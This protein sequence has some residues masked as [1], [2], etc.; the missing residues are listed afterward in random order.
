MGARLTGVR[1]PGTLLE[2]TFLAR[3]KRFFADV[4]LP[5][6]REVVAHCANTGSMGGLLAP[7][8]RCR[9]SWHDNPKRKLAWSLEQ[10]EIHGTWVMVN[11]ARPNHIVA[12]ALLADGI[13]ELRGFE[14]LY[15][16]QPYGERNS[17]VDLLLTG[18]G[19]PPERARGRAPVD[20]EPRC[21]VEVKNATL[22][23]GSEARFPDAVTARGTRH[24]EELALMVRRG[25]GAAL[26]WHIARSDASSF[27]PADDID[28]AYGA[29]VRAAARAGVKLFAWTTR[30]EA[31][32]VSLAVPV[33]VRL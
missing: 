25:H 11:T 15:S 16:E 32:E 18:S 13:P 12:A 6:G 10:L 2:G 4:R 19:G 29:A 26:V 8:Q 24:M 1:Y 5:D 20:A 9:L 22:V 31:E 30:V 17:R 3:R 14:R 33:P 7:P 28:P 21:Y 23:E 27:A